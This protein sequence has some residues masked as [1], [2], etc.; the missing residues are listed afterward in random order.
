R[1]QPYSV[2]LFDE[3]EKAHADVFNLLLQILED[4]TLT[5]A[6]GRKVSFRN[7]IVILTS[8]LG[9]EKMMKE[10]SLGFHASSDDDEK[11]L[12]QIHAENAEAAEEALA[13]IMRPELINRFDSIITFRALTNKQINKIFDILVNELQQRLVP[14]GIHLTINN[15]AKKLL[16]SLGY[17][18]KFGARPLRRVIQDELEHRIA[19]GVLSGSYEKGSVLKI[20]IKGDEIDINVSK[21]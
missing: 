14:K 10:S 20:G 16:T 9:A 18:E 7:A 21:E 13:K 5:D 12:A 17:S 1:R 6:K 19:E 3:I 2:V 15:S 8:N 11:K 4:G